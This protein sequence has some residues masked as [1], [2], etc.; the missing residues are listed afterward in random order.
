[1]TP[2]DA[3]A[4]KDRIVDAAF[5][6]FTERG[7]DGARVDRIAERAGANKSLLYQY[8]GDKEHLFRHVLECK[9]TELG[10]IAFEPERIA[11]V[12]GEFFD[13]HARNP[14]LTRLL[15]WEALDRGAEEVPNEQARTE[16]L[17]ARVGV[18]EEAQEAGAVDPDLDPEQTTATLMAVVT[19]WFACPQV[20]RMLAG[21]DPYSRKALASRRA[22]VIDVA[23]RILEVR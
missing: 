7:F 3:A 5:D 14:W 12:A 9:T 1:M 2:R 15:L 22:H 19:F 13:F 18:L 8:F 23:R 21:G 6:E 16:Q 17:R 10:R 20:A 4:T 11:E